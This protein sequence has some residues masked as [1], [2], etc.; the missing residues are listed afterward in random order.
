MEADSG[1]IYFFSNINQFKLGSNFDLL[2]AKL[3]VMTTATSDMIVWSLVLKFTCRSYLKSIC[4]SFQVTGMQRFLAQNFME[5][6]TTVERVE[7]G[8]ADQI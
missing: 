1:N 3:N 8:L 5:V 6:K 2:I 4:C 7:K